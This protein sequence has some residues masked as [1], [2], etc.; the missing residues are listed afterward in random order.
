MNPNDL[1]P[2]KRRRAIEDDIV[3]QFR[4]VNFKQDDHRY[5]EDD[6]FWDYI[7]SWYELV[8]YYE[9]SRDTAVG[10]HMLDLYQQCARRFQLAAQQAPTERRRDK[11]ADAIY[12]M[13]YYVDRMIRQAERNGIENES[14]QPHGQINWAKTD[15]NPDDPSRLN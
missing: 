5:L 6:D 4:K 13:T 10:A 12:Q 14:D 8:K 2:G 11:A 9:K 7:F 15:D 1:V 3:A